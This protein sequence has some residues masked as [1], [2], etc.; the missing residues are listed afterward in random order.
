MSIVPNGPGAPVLAGADAQA[1]VA[2]VRAALRV[3][4]TDDDALIAALAE[5][6]LGLA[7]QFTGQVLL[8]RAMTLPMMAGTRWWPIAATPVVAVTGVT[9]DAG[10]ALAPGSWAADIDGDGSAWLRCD[11]SRRALV[12]LTAG[13]ANGWNELPAAIREGV[14]LCAVHLFDARADAAPP[15]AITALWRP[16]RRMRLMGETRA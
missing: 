3:S 16:Y 13:I 14:A 11:G 8:R 6:A 10:V 5:T 15:A 7:E 1:A 9:D 2:A 4:I 12:A